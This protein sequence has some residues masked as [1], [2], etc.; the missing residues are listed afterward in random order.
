MEDCRSRLGLDLEGLHKQCCPRLLG[1]EL[2]ELHKERFPR[3]GLW[4]DFGDL[5]VL[6]L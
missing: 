5:L 6:Y 2:E 1:L 3:L 4:P